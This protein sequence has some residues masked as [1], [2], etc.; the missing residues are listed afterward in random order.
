MEKNLS[1]K[2]DRQHNSRG[3]KNRSAT[4][5][6]PDKTHKGVHRPAD[7]RGNTGVGVATARWGGGG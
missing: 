7:G 4:I 6:R 5:P 2:S 1:N 3:L